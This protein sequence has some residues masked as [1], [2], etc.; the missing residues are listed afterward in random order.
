MFGWIGIIIAC[1]LDFSYQC[2]EI[3]RYDLFTSEAECHAELDTN[4]ERLSENRGHRL[5]RDEEVE[6]PLQDLIFYGLC[7]QPMYLD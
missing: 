4:I 3:K 7:K 6:G 1:P 5:N 2:Y